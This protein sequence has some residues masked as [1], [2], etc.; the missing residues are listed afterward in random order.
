VNDTTTLNFRVVYQGI[1]SELRVVV[2]KEDTG[3]AILRFVAVPPLLEALAT[4]ISAIEHNRDA[5]PIKK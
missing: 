5:A 2:K 4:A 3:A 1:K